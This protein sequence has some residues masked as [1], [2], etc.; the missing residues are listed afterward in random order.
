M[1]S[2]SRTQDPLNDPSWLNYSR[3][4][5]KPMAQPA[6]EGLPASPVMPAPPAAPARPNL[7]VVTPRNESWETIGRSLAQGLDA[8]VKNVYGGITDKIERDMRDVYRNIQSSE[9]GVGAA[10]EL[11][12]MR[13]APNDARGDN[14]SD[15]SI[16]TAGGEGGYLSTSGGTVSG[17]SQ[18]RGLPPGAK[19][20]VD[21]MAGFNE[22][23]KSGLISQSYYLGVMNAV[24][25]QFKMNYPG[26]EKEI[27]HF[28]KDQ[29]GVNPANA[30]RQSLMADAD[31]RARALNAAQSAEIKEIAAH[32]KWLPE[33]AYE[34]Y[35]KGEWSMDTIRKQ[36]MGQQ[37]REHQTQTQ[38]QFEENNTK[39]NTERSVR[40]SREAASN[41]V[42]L[43]MRNEFL[44]T[45]IPEMIE[46]L[47]GGYQ[48]T[49]D[50]QRGFQVSVAQ[51]EAKLNQGINGIFKGVDPITGKRATGPNG[52]TPDSF[53]SNTQRQDVVAAAMAPFKVYQGLISDKQFTLAGQ[54]ASVTQSMDDQTMYNFTKALGMTENQKLQNFTL[55]SKKNPAIAQLLL[56]PAASKYLMPIYESMDKIM[57]MNLMTT[58]EP[59]PHV[60]VLREANKVIETPEDRARVARANIARMTSI[61][62][63]P[64]ATT[65]EIVQAA[66]SLYHPN[67]NIFAPGVTNKNDHASVYQWY[68]SPAI[69][70]NIAT[71]TDPLT[72]NRY[73]KWAVDYFPTAVQF[74]LRQLDQDLKLDTRLS[75][76]YN[77]DTNL[78]ELDTSKLTPQQRRAA[79]PYIEGVYGKVQTINQSVSNLTTILQAGKRDV[80]GTMDE[81]FTGMGVNLN[82][83]KPKKKT[84]GTP[85]EEQGGPMQFTQDFTNNNISAEQFI[86]NPGRVARRGGLQGNLSEMDLT[87]PDGTVIPRNPQMGRP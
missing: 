18:G 64:Q 77:E 31:A 40:W 39:L 36:Y 25:S 62:A 5:D 23:H 69:T 13:V 33:N 59:K 8:S 14:T 73:Q 2:F 44:R 48:P 54:W 57:G 83:G 29:L 43:Q 56:N 74:N 7:E 38:F 1:A 32:A 55:L 20:L 67:N 9:F 16:L 70:Q 60:D 72:F 11:A 47:K 35:R 10:T 24:M 26:F 22:M 82:L 87:L 41:F 12:G 84:E 15:V 19:G 86:S 71:K 66:G 21:K 17:K 28:A 75:V 49:P 42:G 78:F 58:P 65:E 79:A 30:L 63:A 50:E 76:K 80:K 85:P 45:G 34:M 53:L 6:R 37:A 51:F 27:E 61:V 68:T 46:K 81:L 52:E 3:E 4:T